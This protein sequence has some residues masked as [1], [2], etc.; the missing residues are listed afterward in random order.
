MSRIPSWALTWLAWSGPLTL[1]ACAAPSEPTQHITA[2]DPELFASYVQPYLEVGCATLDCHGDPGHPLRLYSELGLRKEAALRPAA[3]SE[4][5]E[6]LAL[7]EAELADN[8]LSLAAIALAS[9]AAADHLALRKPLAVSA[10]GVEHTGPALWTSTEAP[11]YRCLSAY[12][13]G[14]ASGDPADACA[15]ALDR[16]ETATPAVAE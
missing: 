11:G 14:E 3:I 10:G 1:V 5:S 16:L 8:R 7:T 6:P 15:E 4:Q 12:L 9:R 2:G 13:L